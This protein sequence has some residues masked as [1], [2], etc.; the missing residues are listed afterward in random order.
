MSEKKPSLKI[1]DKLGGSFRLDGDTTVFSVG[2]FLRQN[3]LP[4]DPQLRS[5]VIAELREMFPEVRVMEEEN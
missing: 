2:E 4:D 5:V 3:S 1:L